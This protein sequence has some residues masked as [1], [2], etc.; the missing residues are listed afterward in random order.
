[1]SLIDQILEEWSYRVDSGMPNPKNPLH[2]IHLQET[3][4]ELRL[5]RKVSEKLLNNLRQIKERDLVKNKKSGNT[6]D[7]AKHNPDTQNLVKKDASDAEIEKA[8][9][10]KE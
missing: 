7:V 4:D 10:D 1:M 3:L 8:K 2:L 5:P 9:Q 6:Y